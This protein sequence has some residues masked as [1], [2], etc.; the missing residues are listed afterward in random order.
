MSLLS[1]S[2][3]TRQNSGVCHHSHLLAW[4]FSLW[5]LV[6]CLHS[7]T[8]PIFRF[9]TLVLCLPRKPFTHR[10]LSSAPLTSFEGWCQL[11]AAVNGINTLRK[12]KPFLLSDS[13]GVSVSGR[14]P[15]L[16]LIS[17]KEHNTMWV[18]GRASYFPHGSR[19]VMRGM[20]V[21][22]TVP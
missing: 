11:S 18:C 19:G 2:P 8:L 15:L 14:L 20:R 3:R 6:L 4:V 21:R 9:W 22:A 10:T 5:T 13:F 12:R 16:L 1:F 17:G 7:S